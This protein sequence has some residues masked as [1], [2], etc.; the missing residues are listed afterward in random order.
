M[1]KLKKKTGLRW[2]GYRA[3]VTKLRM[4]HRQMA[5]AVVVLLCACCFRLV[6]DCQSL[7]QKLPNG[8]GAK[9]VSFLQKCVKK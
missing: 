5:A 4:L 3:G 7:N 8:L 1:N 9:L 6:S 2:K